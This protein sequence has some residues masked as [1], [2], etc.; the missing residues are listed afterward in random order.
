MSPTTGTIRSCAPS[1]STSRV[2]HL[3]LRGNA[4]GRRVLEDVGGELAIN[5]PTEAV[6]RRLSLSRLDLL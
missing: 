6:H 4:I 3:L 1:L 5:G 2:E